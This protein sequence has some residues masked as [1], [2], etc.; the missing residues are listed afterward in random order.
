MSYIILQ[1]KR[2]FLLKWYVYQKLRA[3]DFFNLCIHFLSDNINS[4]FIKIVI[5]F[6]SWKTHENFGWI[7]FKCLHTLNPLYF[8][9]SAEPCPRGSIAFYCC[10]VIRRVPRKRVYKQT[11][12]SFNINRRDTSRW[13]ITD[14]NG[15]ASSNLAKMNYKNILLFGFAVLCPLC[16][17]TR[18]AIWKPFGKVTAKAEFW[19]FNLCIWR[20]VC[21]FYNRSK[22]CRSNVSPKRQLQLN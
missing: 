2:M 20:A 6:S 3:I 21:F 4:G 5:F 8:S 14:S 16:A 18:N 19:Y 9:C 17:Q 10:A 11:S 7:R 22:T 12:E 13:W 15:G 1:Y